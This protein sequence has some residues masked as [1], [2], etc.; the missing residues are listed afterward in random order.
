MSS[1]RCAPFWA[2]APFILV[3][4][5]WDFYPFHAAAQKCTTTALNSFTRFGL[6]LGILLAVLRGSGAYLGIALGLAAIAMIIYYTLKARGALREGF[7]TQA[8]TGSQQKT[9]VGPTLI[10]TPGIESPLIGGQDVANAPV[11]DVIGQT[12]RTVPTAENPFMNVLVNEIKTNPLRGP[13]TNTDTPEMLRTFSD[14]F[15]TRLYGDSTDVF[16]HSQNQRTWV[17]Q[18]S[19]SIPNDRESFQNWLYRVP[20]R[21]CK[22]GNLS[23]CRTGTEAGSVPWLAAE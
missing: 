18:P 3:Q 13:A 9:I 5:A 17:T 19:T 11:A 12:H 1:P 8:A 23:V 22:E 15:Q 16:Q 7:E 2:E 10:V 20:G 21:T 6:Y 4:E 14:A